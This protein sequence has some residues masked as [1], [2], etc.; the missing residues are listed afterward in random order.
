MKRILLFLNL[1]SIITACC[2]REKVSNCLYAAQC[3]IPAG[4]REEGMISKV[5]FNGRKITNKKLLPLEPAEENNRI[6]N[7]V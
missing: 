2:I 3:I 1:I 5:L 6:I 4:K 7:E